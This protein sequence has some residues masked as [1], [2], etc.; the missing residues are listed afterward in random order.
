MKNDFWVF[1]DFI[2]FHIY[3]ILEG[4]NEENIIYISF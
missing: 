4:K 1:L 3:I 2:V